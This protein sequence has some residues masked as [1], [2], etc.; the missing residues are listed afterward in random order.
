MLFLCDFSVNFL[1]LARV[2]I[3][4]PENKTADVNAFMKQLDHPLKDAIEAVRDIIKSNP[5]ISERVKWNAPSFFTDDLATI[6][7]KARQHVH[8]IF[9]HPAI[10]SIQSEFLEGDYKDR[11]MMYFESMKE[12]KARKKELTRII[13]EL[14]A[15]VKE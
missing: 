5:D 14:V 4:N 1:L 12:V 6:H 3:M 9:H 7:V 11:R 13:K 2:I 8:L 15:R 10:V